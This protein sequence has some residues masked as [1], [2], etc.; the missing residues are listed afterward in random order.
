MNVEI[1]L[2]SVTPWGCCLKFLSTLFCMPNEKKFDNF[3]LIISI[4]ISNNKNILQVLEY[5]RLMS[6]M[7][8]TLCFV[9]ISNQQ[10]QGMCE[11]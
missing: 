8:S 3:F 2:F 1:H 10:V 6:G 9:G 4:S 11:V 5:S 7:A